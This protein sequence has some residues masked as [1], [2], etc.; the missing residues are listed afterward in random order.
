MDIAYA[1]G[2]HGPIP[3]VEFP[4]ADHPILDLPRPIIGICNGW[5]RTERMYWEKKGW[6]HFK[7]LSEVLRGYFGGSIVGIGGKGEVPLGVI[8]DADFMGRLPILQSAKVVSQLDLLI[9][10]DTGPMHLANI[11]DVPTIA[12]FG[13]TLV[14]KNGPRG[15]KS[16]VLISGEQC[17]P[18]QDKSAF[19]GCKRFVCMEAIKVSDVMTTARRELNGTCAA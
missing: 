18:C 8:L 10:T 17:A 11:L 5:F 3:K 13:P 16:T 6:P 12:L 15:E 2:Y 9:T 1:M 7:R 14:S 4:V 19:Y